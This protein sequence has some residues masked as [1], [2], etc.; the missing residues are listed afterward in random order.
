M[1]NSII[2]ICLF[3]T[4]FGYG[5][6]ETPKDSISTKLKEVMVSSQNKLFTNKNGNIKV[7]VANSIYNSTPST[8]GL[9]AKMPN[10]QVSTDKESITVIGKGNPLIYID[11]QKVGINDLNSLAVDAIK[12]IEIINNPSSKYEASGRVVILIA[13]KLSKKE[14]FETTLSEIASFKKYFNNYLGI[15]STLKKNKFEFKANFDY[16]QVKIWESNGNNFTIPSND[17]ISNYLVKAVTKRPQFIFGGAAFYKINE[18]DYFSLNFG[19]RSQKDIFDIK[20][21]TYNPQQSTINEVNTFNANDEKRSF[22]NGFLNYNHKIKS[23]DGIL[24][25]G[26]QY[27]KFN[28]EIASVISNNY[29]NTG[30]ELSQNRNQKINI[31]VFSGRFDFEKE[32][33]NKTKLEFGALYLRANSN[34]NFFVQNESPISIINSD[35]NYKEKNSAVYSQFSGSI[36]KINYSFGLRA[37]NTIVKGKYQSEKALLIDKNYTNLFPKVTVEIPIDS[38]NTINLNYGKSISRPNFSSTSQVSA[39]INPYFVWSNNINLDPTITDEV[40]LSYQ[41]KEKSVK[42]SY[43]KISNPVYYGSSYDSAQNILTLKNTNF[44]KETGFNLEFTVPF[45]YK[46]WTVTNTLNFAL[47]KIE[48]SQAV[49]NEAKPYLYYYS[50]HSFKLPK[51][52][53][54]SLTGWGLT[55][56]QQGIFER[57]ALFTM[58]FA[59]S[60]TLFKHFDCAISYNDIFK[61]MKFNENFTINTISAKGIYYTDSNLVSV[62]VKYSFGKIKNPEFKEKNIDENSS[63]IR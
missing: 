3:I 18:E 38:T 59:I 19:R 23:I 14:G 15:N 43:N 35:Y 8:L 41:Y 28:Q 1:K 24:F 36:K 53:E 37:E 13:R 21:Q 44:E 20:T 32:F 57:S 22:S 51:E 12:S 34:T 61:Q 27:S 60:K 40:A 58:D 11:N 54:V 42:V 4:A 33:K 17:I 25:S 9:L 7:D 47:S 29:N 56:Q 55:K 62:S 2:T 16:N 48:D 31:A 45:K 26:F 63:R 30:F 10:I 49:V 6:K 39:Y 5:Q 46:F 50:N 52:I